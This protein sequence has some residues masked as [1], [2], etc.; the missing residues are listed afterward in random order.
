MRHGNDRRHLVQVVALLAQ[1]TEH[2][3]DRLPGQ[4]TIV[5][6]NW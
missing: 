2:N 3:R 1:Q 5:M 4:L 6:A